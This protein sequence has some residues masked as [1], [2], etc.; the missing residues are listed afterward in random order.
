MKTIILIA[1]SVFTS[2]SFAMGDRLHGWTCQLDVRETRWHRNG[3]PLAA[4]GRTKADAKAAVIAECKMIHER[5]YP[6]LC[7]EYA[8]HRPDN[9]SCGVKPSFNLN[10]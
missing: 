4:S 8:E 5:H 10:W 6:G 2:T 7:Q 3:H 9:F 1:L